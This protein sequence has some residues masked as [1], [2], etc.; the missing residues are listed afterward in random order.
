MARGVIPAELAHVVH[1]V[2]IGVDADLHAQLLRDQLQQG[3]V[4]VL[5]IGVG[6]GAHAVRPAVFHVQVQEA[7]DQVF[8]LGP[9]GE[10]RRV[11]QH[12]GV[13]AAVV[14]KVVAVGHVH[15]HPVEVAEAV[16]AFISVQDALK[17]GPPDRA[18]GAFRIK[19][20]NAHLDLKGQVRRVL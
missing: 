8:S 14:H 11:G 15:Q 10:L 5:V 1:G 9:F 17:L 16:L 13:P 2:G 20:P 12:A 7:L 18:Q 3:P 19:V 6:H 4:K